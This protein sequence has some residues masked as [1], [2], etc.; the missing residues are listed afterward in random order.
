MSVSN[1]QEIQAWI[2]ERRKRFPTAARIAERQA[3]QEKKKA[4]RDAKRKAQQDTHRTQKKQKQD[5]HQKLEKSTKAGAVEKSASPAVVSTK[6]REVTPLDDQERQRRKMQKH[7]R[8]AE[9]L[10]EM[11]EKTGIKSEGDAQPPSSEGQDVKIAPQ[12]PISPSESS[13]SSDDDDV[14]DSSPESNDELPE[15]ESSKTVKARKSDDKTPKANKVNT[16]VPCKYF[17][18]DGHCRRKDCR[19]LHKVRKD[20]NKKGKMTLFERVCILPPPLH[21][22]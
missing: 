14:S 5:N 10:R 1:A 22:I 9:K 21:V 16:N 7:L 19:F 13:E 17:L 3:F 6:K 15:V 18:R 12:D 8:K 4:E 20:V 2:S 11:L